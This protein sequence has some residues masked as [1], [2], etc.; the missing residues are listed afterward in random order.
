VRQAALLPAPGR[1]VW[2]SISA[3]RRCARQPS[4]RAPP[5]GATDDEGCAR[6]M[7]GS[8]AAG[9]A[10]SPRW[11]TGPVLPAATRRFGGVHRLEERRR[12][13]GARRPA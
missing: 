1:P 13:S 3:G 8:S 4:W 2:G 7:G 12:R 6:T 10:G 9:T 5:S 11:G